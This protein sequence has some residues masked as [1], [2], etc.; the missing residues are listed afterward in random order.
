MAEVIELKLL[1]VDDVDVH[2]YLLKAGLLRID[3]FMQIDIV[4]SMQHAQEALAK[5]N[6]DAVVSD[7]MMPSGGGHELLQWM[8]KRPHYKYVP[9]IMMSARDNNEDVIKAF[10]QHGVDDYV[11]KPFVPENVYQKIISAIGNIEKKRY[12][13]S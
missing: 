4:N 13:L 7:W 5:K 3:P 12:A 6:Y 2:L 11:V 8:R 10:V 1:L 9:F